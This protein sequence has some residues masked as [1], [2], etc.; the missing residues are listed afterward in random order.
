M[1][2]EVENWEQLRLRSCVTKNKRAIKWPSY[3]EAYYQPTQP[4]QISDLLK[5]AYS[6]N[7]D[8]H[9]PGVVSE[10]ALSLSLSYR[11]IKTF[12]LWSFLLNWMK[13]RQIS[14]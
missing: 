11:P 3:I 12:I 6:A 7:T 1:K 2:A 14:D 10:M 5:K 13:M 4:Q 8:V 9:I